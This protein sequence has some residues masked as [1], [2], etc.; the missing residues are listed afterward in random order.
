MLLIG[1]MILFL[2]TNFTAYSQMSSSGKAEVKTSVT[3]QSFEDFWMD[4]SSSMGNNAS[5]NIIKKDVAKKCLFPLEMNQD[6][7]VV[8]YNQKKFLKDYDQ[9]FE[10]N[11]KLFMKDFSEFQVMKADE[12]FAALGV[13]LGSE[14]HFINIETSGL[15]WNYYK[16][17]FGN[18]KGQYKLIY[19]ETG[20]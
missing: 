15:K 1:V 5:G 10:V 4:L 3:K 18:V 16:Y 13:E 9:I 14:I 20:I 19:I 11:D 17:Y 12:S 6:G 2:V 8:K 7:N